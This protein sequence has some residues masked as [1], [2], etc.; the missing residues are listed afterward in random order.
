MFLGHYA[1]ALAAKAYRPELSLG[2]LFVT[3]QAADIGGSV[4][5]LF[6]AE[7]IG[8]QRIS[9]GLPAI[10]L[11]GV[12]GWR[13]ARSRPAVFSRTGARAP[14]L[15]ALV[16]ASHCGLDWLS[17]AVDAAPMLRFGG[18]VAM[19]LAA[20]GAYAWSRVRAGTQSWVGWPMLGLLAGLIGFHAVVSFGSPPSGVL[21]YAASNLA[22]FQLLAV[23]VGV[24]CND[25]G[26]GAPL[27]NAQGR[28]A[29]RTR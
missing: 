17:R 15:I 7:S 13:L 18:E 11:L 1:V 22:A 6:G 10:L 23:L 3:A 24:A 19:L 26:H 16:A 9:H 8:D 5:L 12:G 20:S 28:V 14:L 21:A 2:G 29:G 27:D 25:G 4:L